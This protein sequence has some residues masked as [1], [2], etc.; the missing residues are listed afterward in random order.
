MSKKL[1]VEVPAQIGPYVMQG[2]IGDGAFSEV[3]LCKKKKTKEF[4]ACKIVPRSRLHSAALESRFEY[5]IRINQQL[6][7]P[8]I[9]QMIDLLCDEK[10]Y[11]V[12]MEFCPNGDLFSYIVNRNKLTEAQAKPFVRQILEALQYLHSMD[13]SHRDMKPENILLDQYARI[14]IS[15]FGLS[16]FFNPKDC[17]VKTPC[18]SPCYASPECISGHAYNGKTTDVWSFGVI[19]YAMLTGQLPWTKRNQTQLFQQIKRG[20]YSIPSYLSPEAKNMIRNLMCVNIESRYTIEQALNDPWIKDIPKQFDEKEQHGY[21]SMK[22]VDQYFGRE[23]SSLDLQPDI[24]IFD[25]QPNFTFFSVLRD[26]GGA[27]NKSLETKEHKKIVDT[28]DEHKKKKKVKKSKFLR[29]FGKKDNDSETS[30]EKAKDSKHKK[31]PPQ[32]LPVPTAKNSILA[33]SS[34][35]LED[36]DSN[37]SNVPSAPV[38]RNRRRHPNQS[39]PYSQSINP[40]STT[41]KPVEKTREIKNA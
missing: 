22:Q 15:D 2:P 14:K 13:V 26:I 9:V 30:K 36:N 19:L 27:K 34:I 10:N 8:G 16:K 20:E 33:P 1:N 18:G 5:E 12:I 37:Y 31:K 24:V 32:T 4:F 23:I 11:Y 21:V 35:S 40:N 38:T 41:S 3:R 17:L 25:S 7:H 39:R 28:S 6:H 29:F